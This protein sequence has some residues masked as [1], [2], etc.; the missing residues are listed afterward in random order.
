MSAKRY[1]VT[2][3][4]GRAVAALTATADARVID[5]TIKM[6]RLRSPMVVKL[7]FNRP[8]LQYVI[9]PKKA[10]AG[11]ISELTELIANKFKSKSGIVYCLSRAECDD[12]A[13]A[14]RSGGIRAIPYHAGL[15]DEDRSEAQL[16]WINGTSQVSSASLHIGV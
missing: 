2:F 7:S 13:K 6:L 10:K 5:D 16:K 15:S 4:T 8:N 14:L 12:I 3:E 11:M 1:G 9:L